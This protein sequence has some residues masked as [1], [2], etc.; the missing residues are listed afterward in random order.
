M[1][2]ELLKTQD[3]A[4]PEPS[5]E[6]RSSA[7]WRHPLRDDI[8]ALLA[9]RS[10]HW[11]SAWLEE[12]YPLEDEEGEAH[13]DARRHEKLRLS[14]RAIER[15]RTKFAPETAGAVDFLPAE[16]EDLIGRHLPAPV[17]ARRELDVLESMQ[18]VALYN[19]SRAMENDE[20]MDMLQPITL[21][22]QKQ[23]VSIAKDTIDAKGKLGIAG[24]EVVPQEFKIDQTSRNLNVELQGRVDKHGNPVPNDPEKV[25]AIRELLAQGPEDARRTVRAARE[26]TDDVI[27]GEEA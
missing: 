18:H 9:R 1:A 12:R 7:V 20:A 17:A 13:P 2:S 4:A 22:A 5:D 23:A 3:G 24:Y 11:I 8:V 25:A 14:A 6:Q 15:Y 10:A 16:L 21:E 27:D 26:R 19:L